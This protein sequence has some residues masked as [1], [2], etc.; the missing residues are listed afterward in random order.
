M[1]KINQQRKLIDDIDNQIMN[2]LDRRFTITKTIGNLKKDLN[3]KVLDTKR[4]DVIYEKISKYS[5]YPL[6][7]HVYETIMKVSKEAQRK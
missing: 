2:L 7:K 6:I 4:E 1:D 5:H 3:V